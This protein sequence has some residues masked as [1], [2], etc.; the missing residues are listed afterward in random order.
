MY[1]II[2]GVVVIYIINLLISKIDLVMDKINIKK[3]KKLRPLE[4]KNLY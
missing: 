4:D 3:Y 2:I 1:F